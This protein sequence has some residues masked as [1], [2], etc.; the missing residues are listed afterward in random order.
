MSDAVGED[1]GVVFPDPRSALEIVHAQYWRELARA[2]VG[3]STERAR[4]HAEA[5]RLLA[6]AVALRGRVRPP[7]GEGS[8]RQPAERSDRY[9]A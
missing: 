8:R 6:V 1:Q 5:R 3:E 7:V 4:V 2:A 9:S